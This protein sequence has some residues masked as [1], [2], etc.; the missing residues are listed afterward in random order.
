M[1]FVPQR[2]GSSHERVCGRLAGGDSNVAP[3]FFYP[4]RHVTG[5]LLKSMGF[6]FIRTD[7]VAVKWRN[8]HNHNR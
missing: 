5:T 8:I 7:E 3:A 6:E 4:P 1:N 2:I